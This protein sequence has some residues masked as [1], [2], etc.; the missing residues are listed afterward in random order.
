M[1]AA[2]GSTDLTIT[3]TSNDLIK[4][5]VGLKLKPRQARAIALSFTAPTIEDIYQGAGI[6]RTTYWRWRTDPDFKRGLEIARSEFLRRVAVEARRLWVESHRQ[7]VERFILS[8]E[9]IPP[10][11]GV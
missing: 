3:V 7:Y 11:P 5:L 10:P 4:E 1:I 2:A 9:M 8:G 6:S